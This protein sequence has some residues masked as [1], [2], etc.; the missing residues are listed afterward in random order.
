[1]FYEKTHSI[2]GAGRNQKNWS[3]ENHEATLNACYEV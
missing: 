3:M 1:M 2:T